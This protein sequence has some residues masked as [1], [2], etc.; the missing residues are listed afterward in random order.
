MKPDDM[1]EDWRGYAD[2]TREYIRF[3]QDLGLQS[4][5][6]VETLDAADMD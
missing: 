3:L 6:S 4:E 5:G 1:L 2:E